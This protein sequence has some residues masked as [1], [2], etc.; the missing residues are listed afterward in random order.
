MASR[1]EGAPTLF[2]GARFWLA[3]TVPQR[4]RFREDIQKHGGFVVLMEKDADVKL[5]DHKRKNL[6]QNTF[7]YQYVE[8]SIANG[9][10]EDLEAHR[11][12]PSATRPMGATNIP[13]KGKRSVFTLKDDQIVYDWIHHFAKS[14]GA[15][16]QGNKFYQDLSE[17]FP[18]H[19]WQSW[20]SRYTK[21]LHGKPRPGGGVPL[22]F[23]EILECA[24]SQGQRARILPTRTTEPTPAAA[25]R[26]AMR[27]IA[28]KPAPAQAETSNS[29]ANMKRKRASIPETPN[30]PRPD[31]PPKRRAVEV[32]IP[33]FKGSPSRRPPQPQPSPTITAAPSRRNDS[34]NNS[35]TDFSSS[36]PQTG[37]GITE[38]PP[39][40]ARTPISHPLNRPTIE[41][42]ETTKELPK[43]PRPPGDNAFAQLARFNQQP[44]KPR[45]PVR[46]PLKDPIDSIDP[47]FL[48]LPFPPP[49]PEPEA[50]DDDISEIPDIDTWMDERLARG[51]NETHIFNALACTSM[52]PMMADKILKHL[53]AGKGIP[54]NV[55]GVWTAED[56]ECFQSEEYAKVQRA[57]SKHGADAYK[58]RWEYFRGARESGFIE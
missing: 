35:S 21:V 30:Q 15:P 40:T 26:P 41:R 23:D 47:G 31:L 46:D 18:S 27:P 57:L 19:P 36:S 38:I 32:Q 43:L 11:S 2:G 58:A 42:P 28:P 13:T 54:R 12:G 25:M 34:E 1:G 29:N 33:V 10:L 24:P 49:S 48:E 7:S 39:Q 3:Q 20:R 8:R 50:T 56:D 9:Q 45:Q 37:L 52:D 22:T 14:P 44:T 17:L 16:V 5:V 6:P 4:T 53:G 55:R 51:V